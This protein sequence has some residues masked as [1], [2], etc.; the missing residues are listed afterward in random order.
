M[1]TID[2]PNKKSISLCALLIA[3]AGFVVSLSQTLSIYSQGDGSETGQ[4][5]AA[6]RAINMS[7]VYFQLSERDRFIQQKIRSF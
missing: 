4:R 7:T 3:V 5:I 1:Y 2:W 6:V